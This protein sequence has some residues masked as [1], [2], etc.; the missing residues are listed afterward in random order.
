MSRGG[1]GGGGGDRVPILA[2]MVTTKNNFKTAT[3]MHLDG[4]WEG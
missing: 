1:G 3:T 2:Y 4:E